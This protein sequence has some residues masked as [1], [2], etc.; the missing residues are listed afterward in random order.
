[1]KK[2]IVGLYTIQTPLPEHAKQQA[3]LQV[4][5]FPTLSRDEL[6]TEEKYKK[7]LE[8]FPEGQFVVLDGTKVIASSTTFRQNYHKGKHRFLAISD[9]LWLGTHDP[10]ADWIYGLDVSVHPDYRG[11]GIARELYNARQDLA[12]QQGCKGQVTA[13]MPIGFDKV[14]DQM[15]IADYCDKVIKGEI[16]DP[17]VTAQIKCGFIPVEPLFEYLDDPR[18][19]NC[20]ILMFRPLDSNTELSQ[21]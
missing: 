6:I 7:H 20:A 15:T 4:L 1:M 2:K 9:N 3:E 17:T 13:G 18:S 10:T 16:A 5:V 14:K 21:K 19:G 11:K 8:I 12:K